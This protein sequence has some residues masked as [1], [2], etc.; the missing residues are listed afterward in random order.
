VSG[1]PLF[2]IGSDSGQRLAVSGAQGADTLLQA[3]RQ[4]QAA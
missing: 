3:M 2:I 1:V 4:V